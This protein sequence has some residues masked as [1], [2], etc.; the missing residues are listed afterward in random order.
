[1]RFFKA[2]PRAAKGAD[3]D[4]GASDGEAVDGETTGH[5]RKATTGE[6]KPSRWRHGLQETVEAVDG[7]IGVALIDIDGGVMLGVEGRDRGFIETASMGGLDVVR[8]QNRAIDQ[9]TIDDEVEDIL[10]TLTTQYHMIRRLK[11]DSSLLL[12]LAIHRNEGNPG[13]A[14]H[15]LRSVEGRLGI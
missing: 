7:A 12:F 8:A 13:L 11:G 1:M 6:D 15:Q 14:R 9:L 3:E 4:S 5:G 10:I 2:S